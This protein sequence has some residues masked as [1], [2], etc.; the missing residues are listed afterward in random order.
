MTNAH[1]H[2][3]CTHTY[4]YCT[5][6]THMHIHIQMQT[7]IHKVL[8]LLNETH[9]Q[10]LMQNKD[11]PQTHPCM[12]THPHMHAHTHTHTT[13]TQPGF[14]FT[15][16]R[17]ASLFRYLTSLLGK[18]HHPLI[19]F[20]CLKIARSSHCQSKQGDGDGRVTGTNHVRSEEQVWLQCW[21]AARFQLHVFFQVVCPP[22]PVTLL[23][24][25][26]LVYSLAQRH[27]VVQSYSIGQSTKVTKLIR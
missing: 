22:P 9:R 21:C 10:C 26:R 24:V 8:G 4:T 23:I 12:Q 11:T 19:H 17:T 1:T 2:I 16:L 15:R 13:H 6:Y 27:P 7:Y 20:F 5:V 14:P 18:F 3:Q 25:T